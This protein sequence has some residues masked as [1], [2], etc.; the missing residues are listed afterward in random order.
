LANFLPRTIDAVLRS[1]TYGYLSCAP[2]KAEQRRSCRTM[3][4]AGLRLR[5]RDR[6]PRVRDG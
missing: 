4:H 3:T 6:G 2:C 1:E 5:R